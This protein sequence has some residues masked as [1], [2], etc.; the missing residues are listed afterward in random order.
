MPHFFFH[1]RDRDDLTKDVEGVD[2][3]DLEAA[4]AEARASARD[5]LAE[6]IDS[7]G[8]LGNQQF[9]ICDDA[10]QLLATVPFGDAIEPS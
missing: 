5:M 1:V 4:R 9:E 8:T 7:D 6:R 10:G 3:P 2:L